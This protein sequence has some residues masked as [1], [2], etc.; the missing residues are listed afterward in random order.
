MDEK[1]ESMVAA[2]LSVGRSLADIGIKNWGL[3]PAQALGA[4]DA[5]EKDPQLVIVG[6]SVLVPEG[7]TYRHNYDNTSMSSPRPGEDMQKYRQDSF[8]RVRAYI[9][10]Y[11]LQQGVL[12]EL[13]VWDIASIAGNG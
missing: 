5:F 8:F 1:R 3:T 12:Y 2:I 7:D 6:A 9:K 4:I 13:G 10:A 11:P